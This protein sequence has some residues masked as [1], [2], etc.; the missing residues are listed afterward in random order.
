ML[1]AV[2]RG[3]GLV[4]P[5]GLDSVLAKLGDRAAE[6]YREK[7]TAP[8]AKGRLYELATLLRENGVEADVVETERE[9]SNCAS[10]I[11]PTRKPSASTPKSARSSTPYCATRSSFRPC[12][13]NRSQPAAM[14]AGSR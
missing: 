8:D 9:S 1:N 3:Q 12:K 10:T 6:K 7:L 4:G 2:L 14:R 13:S 11:A 5:A